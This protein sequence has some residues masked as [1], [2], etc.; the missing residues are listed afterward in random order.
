MT[1]GREGRQRANSGSDAAWVIGW[2]LAGFAL[3]ALLIGFTNRIAGDGVG[4][5]APMARAFF[6]GRWSQGFDAMIPFVYSLCVAG[7]AHLLPAAAW[8]G[9]VADAGALELAGQLTSAIFGAAAVPL[10]YF[11]LRRL[12]P[13]PH[14]RSAARMGA[15]MAAFSPF[16]SRFG[17]QVMTEPTY[18]FFF[19]L[20]FLAGV[21]LL[22]RRTASSAALFGLAVGL[23]CLNRPE[24]MGLLV[25]IGGWI[26]VPALMQARALWRAVALGAITLLFFLVGLLPQMAVT[27]AKS[28]VWTLSAKS[29]AIFKKSH[30]EGTLASEKW[31]Y[32]APEARTDADAPAGQGNGA[33][34]A[35]ADD[36]FNLVNYVR[37]NPGVF[38]RHYV[39]ALGEFVA[40]V[41]AAMGYVLTPF[42][43]VGLAARREIP[44]L[45][46]EWVAASLVCAYLLMLSLFHFSLRFL[47][48]VVPFGILWASVGLLET[49]ARVGRAAPGRL[50][51]AVRRQ[52]LK[53][54]AAAAL[55]LL[56]V[57]S[58]LINLSANHFRWYWSPEKRTG[59]WMRANLPPGAKV[60]TRSSMIENYYAGAHTSYFPY[61]P[62]EEV[63][64][65]IR[66]TEVA[67]VL[68]DED[69]TTRL[70]PGFIEAFT[71]GGGRLIHAFD[72]GRKK[73]Y[74]YE[75]LPAAPPAAGGA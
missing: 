24:A 27:H 65:Y 13:P 48:P 30:L 2:T 42:L 46:G 9:P 45:R 49:A 22:R 41:P 20:A 74:L 29:G 37:R 38:A 53:W 66:R 31:R 7:V 8:Q 71:A 3:R 62:Y 61:A 67:Y 52:P 60:M 70:R 25:V 63:M 10:I 21:A 11:L 32:P 51:E 68:F 50:P 59:A 1:Q 6:E 4:W 14:G 34:T 18:T 54:I 16:L 23:A 33:E 36:S 28:G 17:A 75:V 5:Y 15:A 58:V 12:L 69:K 43:L 73:V 39:T 55:S 57:E 40:N 35:E 26:A 44:R 72:Y 64:D 47:A 19:L 56:L